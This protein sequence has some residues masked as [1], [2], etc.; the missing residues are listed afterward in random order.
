MIISLND[1]KFLEIKE[2]T[3]IPD[4]QRH[5]SILYEFMVDLAGIL[6]LPALLERALD[7]FF[8]A[9]KCDRG[10][11]LLLTADGEP[12]LKMTKVREGLT[13]NEDILI[14]RTM[15]HQLLQNK[16]SFVTVDASSD[17]RLVASKS[18]HDM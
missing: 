6:H 11:I 8:K 17:E 15:A 2:V 18:L 4:A 5:F 12:G 13:G 7:H 1:T 9:F 3:S 16:E 10:L 14:S